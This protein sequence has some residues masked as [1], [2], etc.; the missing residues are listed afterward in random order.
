M[1]S[2]AEIASTIYSRNQEKY[3]KKIDEMKLHKLLYFVQRESFIQTG[4]PLFN[5]EFEA[6]KFGPVMTEI[7]WRYKVNQIPQ[8]Q[9]DHVTEK[10]IDKVFDIYSKTKSWSLS[11]MSQKKTS[12]KYA[13][14]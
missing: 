9:I 5:E 13:R 2:V 3:G 6:W 4:V 1:F 10:I 14:I 11:M 7:R 12:W 8:C